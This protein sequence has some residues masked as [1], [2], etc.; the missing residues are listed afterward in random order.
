M[1]ARINPHM[2]PNA[3]SPMMAGSSD[4]HGLPLS[5][6]HGTAMY[7]QWFGRAPAACARSNRIFPHARAEM[8]RLDLIASILP[9]APAPAARSPPRVSA[10]RSTARLPSLAAVTTRA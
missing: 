6:Y 8:T 4:R 1:A 2:V 9:P 10:G 7:A 3:K 5:Y